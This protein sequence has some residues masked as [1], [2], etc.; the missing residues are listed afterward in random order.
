MRHPL[1]IGNWKL[2][3]NKHLV[4]N[5]IKEI[6]NKLINISNC[7]VAIAPPVI[8]LDLAKSY[9]NG[10]GINLAAQNVDINLSGAFTGDVSAAMLKDIGVK[11]VIIGH[12]ERRIYHKESNEHIA[13]KFLILKDAGLIPVLCIGENQEEN[14]AGQAELVCAHQLDTILNSEKSAFDNTVIAYEPIWAIG[15]GISPAPAQVQVIHRFIRNYINKSNEENLSKVAI[16]YGG[17]VNSV[18]AE[19]FFSQPDI[20]G[21]LLGGASLQSDIF[22][23]IIKI[24][25]RIKKF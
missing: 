3:G 5:L 1:V 12:S 19:D 24:A 16:Q 6:R 2:N 17:S 25:E 20:D 7:E 22:S 11:Y 13:K 18:N 4:K 14:K 9:I 15:T 10:S 23:K 21:V 8:Y